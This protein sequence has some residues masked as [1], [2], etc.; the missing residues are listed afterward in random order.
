[1][2]SRKINEFEVRLLENLDK[3]SAV[4]ISVFVKTFVAVFVLAGAVG[5][6]RILLVLTKGMEPQQKT[7]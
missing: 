7:K 4:D 6:I 3:A 2:G 1:M 5:N